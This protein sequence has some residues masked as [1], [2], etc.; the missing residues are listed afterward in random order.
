MRT[1][2]RQVLETVLDEDS[3]RSWSPGPPPPAEASYER[4]LA[5]A[6]EASGADAAVI[7]GEGQIHGR[8]VAL[9]VGDF[10]FLGGSIGVHESDLI[11][12]CVRRATAQRL[13]LLASP[14]SGGTRMQEGTVA[15]VRI[16]HVVTA[17]V[18]H[19]R[20]G[21]PY[22]VW[23][24]NPTF[25]GVFASWG[26]LGHITAAEPAAALG[27]LGPRVYSAVA[28]HAFAPGIQV[29]ENLHARGLVDAILSLG[30]VRQEVARAL[31]IVFTP[32]GHAPDHETTFA[33]P[34]LRTLNDAWTSVQ[35][36]RRPARPG[37]R[38]VLKNAG[39]EVVELSGTSR[40]ETGPGMLV[41]FARFGS[42]SCVLVAHDRHAQSSGYPIGPAAIRVARRGI[43]LAQELSLPL[44]SVVDTP[45]AELSPEA[46]EGG[47]SAE[48]AACLADLAGLTV[49]SLCVLLGQGSGGAA[50]ALTATQRVIAAGNAWLAPLPPEGASEIVHRTTSRAAEVAKQQ[51]IDADALASLG[52][53]H[54]VIDELP[55]AAD[56]PHPFSLRI[57]AAIEAELRAFGTR[58]SK[59]RTS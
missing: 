36:T 55:D 23:L 53:V 56:E 37:I 38:D 8:R 30:Q 25:G 49:P 34:P 33:D 28:G 4:E 1:S 6:R 5:R 9:I 54:R 13:P 22:F 42:V 40:G 17:I 47:L 39:V 41:G 32:A 16:R 45:G 21:L 31:A 3:F 35:R 7:V 11:A 58:Q 26:S 57:V 44:V 14:S 18:A 2:A 59:E 20:A 10:A 43:R 29:A 52:V 51:G 50:L 19:R 15:F 12:S 24:R 27:F 48:I 46:E